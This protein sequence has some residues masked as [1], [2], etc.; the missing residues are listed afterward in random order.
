MGWKSTVD[1]SREEVEKA[2]REFLE[3]ATDEEVS[4]GLEGLVGD[5]K[6]YNFRIVEDSDTT[7]D[8][9]IG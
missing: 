2:I 5:R 8:N 7:A 1:I 4:K 6:G 3:D 9:L